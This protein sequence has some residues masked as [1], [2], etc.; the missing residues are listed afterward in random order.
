MATGWSNFSQFPLKAPSCPIWC[1][2]CPSESHPGQG[3]PYR[4][5]RA[6]DDSPL[7]WGTDIS[8]QIR[9]RV[10]H[11]LSDVRL[12]WSKVTEGGSRWAFGDLDLRVSPIW[13]FWLGCC[14]SLRADADPQWLQSHVRPPGP[15]PDQKQVLSFSR[16]RFCS[17]RNRC[18]RLWGGTVACMS[19]PIKQTNE[20]RII[21]T[22]DPIRNLSNIRMIGFFF[23]EGLRKITATDSQLTLQTA[24]WDFFF[25]GKIFHKNSCSA[26]CASLIQYYYIV[27]HL[28]EWIHWHSFI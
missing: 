20:R 3:R 23:K 22:E 17:R 8:I 9:R 2:K 28:Q 4:P 10:I 5:E 15:G 21:S 6:A 1:Q 13:P 14:G 11:L 25:L 27:F 7:S 18:P 26:C 12:G 24:H 16:C 19:G